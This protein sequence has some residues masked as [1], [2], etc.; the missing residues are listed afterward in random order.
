[1]T[2]NVS[3]VVWMGAAGWVEQDVP[4]LT[5]D[6]T[7]RSGVTTDGTH[8]VFLYGDRTG[9]AK[10]TYTGGGVRV[11][12]N[13]GITTVPVS[14]SVSGSGDPGPG[15]GRPCRRTDRDHAERPR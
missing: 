12:S 15:E 8:R 6:P 3:E 9:L 14:I 4:W 10:G 11:I 13:G 5:I 2:W 1:M 7:D